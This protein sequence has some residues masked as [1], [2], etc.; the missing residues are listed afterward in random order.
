MRGAEVT[1][2]CGGFPPSP[3]SA[4][5][6][7][8]FPFYNNVNLKLVLICVC[9]LFE[10][11]ASGLL[12]PIA[13]GSQPLPEDFT[14]YGTCTFHRPSDNKIFLFANSKKAEYLQFEL[15]VDANGTLTTTLVRS[16]KIGT[17]TQPEG[18]VVDDVN[19]VIFIGEEQVGIWKYGAN[20]TDAGTGSGI[21]VDSVDKTTG[22]NIDADV[23]GMALVYGASKSEGYLIVSMQGVSAYNVY[24]RKAPHKFVRRFSIA[25]GE[26]IDGVTNTDG[27]AAVGTGL[28][29]AFGKGLLVV[30]D[31]ANEKKEGG[32]DVNASFKLVS[33]GDALDGFAGVDYKWDPRK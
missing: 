7:P 30:H 16:F 14:I 31:D 11:T 1:I 21:L 2:L 32:T 17:G 12:A 15:G 26:E 13:G 10:I 8:F 23:E 3:A 33:L 18:C 24:E 9:S 6:I 27:V 22:G 20:P 4:A 19:E 5:F 29:G 28:G 25:K